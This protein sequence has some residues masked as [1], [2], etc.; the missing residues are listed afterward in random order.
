MTRGRCSAIP[1]EKR[2][3]NTLDKASTARWGSVE[4]R[5]FQERNWKSG[6]CTGRGDFEWGRASR[7]DNQRLKIGRI[8]TTDRDTGICVALEGFL[9]RQSLP[10]AVKLE[11]G[12]WWW[13]ERMEVREKWETRF[14]QK[15]RKGKKD[16]KQKR[17]REKKKKRRRGEGW[18]RNN[19]DGGWKEK[20]R[21]EEE[22]KM[23]RKKKKERDSLRLRGIRALTTAGGK[24]V[25]AD[26]QGLLSQ[27]RYYITVYR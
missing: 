18:E 9:T 8:E 6:L 24:P 1:G 13:S 10:G 17:S 21:K 27:V 3:K 15:K 7:R 23:R 11:R 5:D 2:R 14:S 4:K 20:E 12:I 25:V 16:E 22:K 26:W 19:N